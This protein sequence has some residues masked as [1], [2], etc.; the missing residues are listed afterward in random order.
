MKYG[1]K[2]NLPLQALSSSIKT[3]HS[4]HPSPKLPHDIHNRK[5]VFLLLFLKDPMFDKSSILLTNHSSNHENPRPLDTLEPD[6]LRQVKVFDGLLLPP[7]E[8][9]PAPD[10]LEF[11]FAVG[12]FQSFPLAFGRI[13][14]DLF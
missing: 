1:S 7:F 12:P 2:P 4:L 13:L 10:L 6:Y 8:I 3:R 11:V 14:P 5:G 9:V